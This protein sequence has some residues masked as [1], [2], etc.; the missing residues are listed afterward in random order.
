MKLISNESERKYKY[1]LIDFGE[2]GTFTNTIDS[3][4]KYDWNIFN[5]SVYE[6]AKDFLD[7]SFINIS[8]TVDIYVK[9]YN[10]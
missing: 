8:N 4:L 2:A 9:K 1:F 7:E 10:F 3:V 5:R 6:L